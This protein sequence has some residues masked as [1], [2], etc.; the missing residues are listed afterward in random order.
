MQ[1]TK[2]MFD[3]FAK[4]IEDTMYEIGIDQKTIEIVIKVNFPK[5]KSQI[6]QAKDTML[7]DQ[8]L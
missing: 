6:I 2:E 1:I 3:Q 5:F 4:H 8:K 7:Q